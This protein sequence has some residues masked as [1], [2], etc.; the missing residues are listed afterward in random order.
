M[1]ASPARLDAEIQRLLRRT[2]APEADL[3]DQGSLWA[4]FGH[5]VGGGK[6]F[7]PGLLLAT[8]DALGGGQEAAALTVAAA[9]ELLHTAFVVQDD[10][11]D[12]DEIRRGT[13]N[14]PGSFAQEVRS[15]GA[16]SH[17]IQRYATAAGILA[18]DLGLVT[19]IRAVASSGASPQ[20]TA[21]LLDLFES[22]IHATARGE[23]ADV[24]LQLGLPGLE[25]TLDQA[26][27][28]AELKTAVY[29][30]Q[31]PLQAGAVLA[32]ASAGILEALDVIGRHL[33][34]GFQIY[35]DLLG[36]FGDPEIT[37]K[38]DLGDLREGKRTALLAH[39]S[40]TPEWSQLAPLVG[41]PELSPEAAREAR[42]LLHR[43]GSRA[44]TEQ[45]AR[46]QLREALDAATAHHLPPALTSA[47][48]A[49]TDDI[50]RTAL[51]ALQAPP[52][53]EHAA[54]PS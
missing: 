10:V 24:R 11:I 37:G 34:I 28:V 44:W 8:H 54:A 43:S 23:L 18:G 6:R 41:D 26:L 2:A 36:V 46:T 40:T 49:A 29:S 51:R 17:G 4:A 50:S 22:T 3:P 33:G 5:A 7:R 53:R 48:T 47:L 20:Q 39:A 45:L 19:T 27:T 42:R 15:R 38:S 30:F 31:L 13:P 9:I 25:T 35:D 12:G 32:D 1:T 16:L 52:T 14:V 21:Q